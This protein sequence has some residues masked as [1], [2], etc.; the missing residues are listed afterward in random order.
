MKWKKQNGDSR[1]QQDQRRVERG[2]GINSRKRVR[3]RDKEQMNKAEKREVR[4][5]KP[6]WGRGN[7]ALFWAR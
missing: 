3:D 4:E 6:P 2:T 5:E 1:E 7:E